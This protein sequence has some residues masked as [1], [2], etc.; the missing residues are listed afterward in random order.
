[1]P[2]EVLLDDFEDTEKWELAGAGANKAHVTTFAEGAPIK[3]PGVYGDGVPGADRRALALL[4][5]GA[6]EGHEIEL[7]ARAGQAFAL[8]GEVSGLDLYVRSP[9]AAIW[10]YGFIAGAGQDSAE[11]LLGRVAAKGEW[12]RIGAELIE[13]LTGAELL[14]LKIRL[15]E[16]VKEAGE[17]MIL[18]DDLTVR[19]SV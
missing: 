7:V 10:V 12:Q 1:M 9:H 13:V 2:N 6:A 11:V 19:S 8:P 15:V 3:D 5:R 4:V 14:G 18:L 17:V 16:V